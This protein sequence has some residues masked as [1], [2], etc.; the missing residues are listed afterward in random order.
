MAEP[1]G[2]EV[3]LPIDALR[4]RVS[5]LSETVISMQAEIDSLQAKDRSHWKVIQDFLAKFGTYYNTDG[6]GSLFIVDRLVNGGGANGVAITPNQGMIEQFAL[7]TKIPAKGEKIVG[8]CW[9][10]VFIPEIAKEEA[11]ELFDVSEQSSG[12]NIKAVA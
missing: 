8:P 3:E 6:H 4:S 7:P 10:P 12:A 5:D 9:V 1:K 2:K 11:V